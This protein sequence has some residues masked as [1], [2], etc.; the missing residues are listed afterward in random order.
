MGMLN[1]LKNLMTKYAI[2]SENGWLSR[3][4][5]VQHKVHV[6]PNSLKK[7]SKILQY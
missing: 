3:E 2:P 5:E 1:S 4:L 7:N 6:S